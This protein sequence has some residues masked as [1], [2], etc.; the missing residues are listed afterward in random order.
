LMVVVA[1]AVH[2]RRNSQR[3]K[4]QVPMF[5]RG[6]DV[7][8]EHFLELTKSLNISALG[9]LLTSPRSLPLNS[10][11]TLTIPAP[12]ITAAALVP[13]G[14]EPIQARVR[15]QECVGEVHLVGVEFQQPLA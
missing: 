8:G 7:Q 4:L 14:M 12:S 2:E 15:H 13:A 6:R 3:I 9:A 5:L 11:V 1:A 10:L